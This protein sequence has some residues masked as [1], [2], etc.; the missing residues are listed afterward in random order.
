[1]SSALT[2]I[3]SKR[4]D[5]KAS[6]QTLNGRLELYVLRVKEMEDAKNVAE[7]ELETIRERMQKDM[8]SLRFRLSGELE[9]TRKKLD[10]EL[11]QKARLQ[12]LEQEQHVELVRLRSQVKE[13][14][15]IKA[16]AESLKVELSKEKANALSSKEE[17][18][19]LTTQLQAA[20]RRIKELERENRNLEATLSDST[21]ELEELRLKSADF[22]LT[23]DSEITNIRKEMNQKHQEALAQWKK[24]TEERL[25]GVEK[26]VRNY[27]EGVVSGLK[28]QV[29][30]L[31]TELDSTK[32][33]LDRTA[34]DYEESLKV[35]QSLTDKVAQL[36]RE[37][38]EER[39]KFK[40]DRKVYE[41]NLEK[42][43]S[44]KVTKEGEFNDLMDVKIALDAEIEAYRRILDREE[45]RVGLPTPNTTPSKHAGRKRKSET[46]SG[47]SKRVKR[48]AAPTSIKIVHLDLE[49][50]RIV[51]ENT[52]DKPVSLGGWE[53]RGR[54]DGQVFRFPNSYSMRPKSKMTVYSSKRNKNAKDERKPNEDSFLATKFSLNPEGDFA[55]LFTQEGVPVC[56]KGEGMPADEIRALEQKVN[57]ELDDAP[58]A[59][60]CGVM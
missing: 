44:W 57:S 7:R 49:K 51:L 8:E 60:G 19:N 36:E 15:E 58:S 33:E 14:S 35:R 1:M 6:L 10:I 45:T 17:L 41:T 46:A 54:A 28:T 52:S 26:E 23:R 32:K 56:T 9:E 2:P 29:E 30:D 40:D 38:R 55:V 3:K 13:L 22:D 42:L 59:E 53:V 21:K 48:A 27:F 16:L 39:S 47:S 24:D 11:D 25:H 5:E 34:N 50:D 43:R 37:Y 31:S 18:S 12:V 20:R 4:L